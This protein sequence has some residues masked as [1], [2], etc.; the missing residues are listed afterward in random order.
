MRKAAKDLLSAQKLLEAGGDCLGNA[1][2]CA[3]QCAEKSLKAWLVYHGTIPKKTHDLGALVESC[4]AL[5]P[6]F[7]S[8]YDDADSLNPFST[9]FR[10]PNEQGEETDPEPAKAKLA[11]GKAENIFSFVKL[12]ISEL[13]EGTQ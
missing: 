5:D 1:V 7:D 13:F 9:L 2:Y 8:I 6:Q 12:K 3:Q 11:I 4:I 10:Y